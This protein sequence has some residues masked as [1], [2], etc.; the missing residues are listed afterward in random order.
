MQ[1]VAESHAQMGHLRKTGFG[2]EGNITESILEE[3]AVDTLVR[4][5]KRLN[6]IGQLVLRTGQRGTGFHSSL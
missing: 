6:S 1:T 5:V 4:L 2:Q 3:R